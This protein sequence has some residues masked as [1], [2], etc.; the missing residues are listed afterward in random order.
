MCVRVR[1]C[2]LLCVWVNLCICVDIYV[3]MDDWGWGGGCMH[4]CALTRV[5][6]CVCVCVYEREREIERFKALEHINYSGS[7][8]KPVLLG[9]VTCIHGHMS[10]FG[11]CCQIFGPV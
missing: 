9:S 2:V 6:V 1:V 5:C 10:K 4:V 7:N 11:L 3:C 8:S